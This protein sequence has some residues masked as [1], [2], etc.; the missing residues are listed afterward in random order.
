MWCSACTVVTSC[1][2]STRFLCLGRCEVSRSEGQTPPDPK[3]WTSAAAAPDTLADLLGTRAEGLA[4]IATAV[5]CQATHERLPASESQLGDSTSL[6]VVFREVWLRSAT[7]LLEQFATHKLRRS[8]GTAPPFQALHE[9]N[10]STRALRGLCTEPSFA[11]YVRTGSIQ[12]AH[13]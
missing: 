4:W 8:C 7:P 3:G 9:N 11:Q 5:D 6:P 1:V 13:F 2:Q 10:N 12:L